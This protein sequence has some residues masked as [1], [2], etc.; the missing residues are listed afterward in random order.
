M[1]NRIRIVQLEDRTLAEH[2]GHSDVTAYYRAELD[3]RTDSRHP[4][5]RGAA[6]RERGISAAF[7]SHRA[8][9]D[10]TIHARLRSF[11]VGGSEAVKKLGAGSRGD[12]E[13]GFYISAFLCGLFSASPRLRVKQVFGEKTHDPSQQILRRP[14]PLP[15]AP[16]PPRFRRLLMTPMKNQ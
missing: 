4:E 14:S 5:R 7:N 3:G 8:S 13:Q 10:I 9:V 11:A 1:G 12:A 15:P 6:G 2:Q 16:P